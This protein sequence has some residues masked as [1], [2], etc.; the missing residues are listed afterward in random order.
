M[1]IENKQSYGNTPRVKVSDKHTMMAMHV[2]CSA[3]IPDTSI[4]LRCTGVVYNISANWEGGNVVV[5]PGLGVKSNYI[6]YILADNKPTTTGVYSK[7]RFSYPSHRVGINNDEGITEA[8]TYINTSTSNDSIY[9]KT[10]DTCAFVVKP[11]NLTTTPN[12]LIRGVIEGFKVF[13]AKQLKA[14]H[15][16]IVKTVPIQSGDLK[17]IDSYID[18][19]LNRKIDETRHLYGFTD[20][21]LYTATAKKHIELMR[22]MV[23]SYKS[24]SKEHI[25]SI[26]SKL[27]S[28]NGYNEES[29][30]HSALGV[31]YIVYEIP[32]VEINDIDETKG[33]HY[34]HNL[35]VVVSTRKFNKFDDHPAH[36][37]IR[38]NF[39]EPPAYLDKVSPQLNTGIHYTVSNDDNYS[40]IYY[41]DVDTVCELKPVVRH[42]SPDSLDFNVTGALIEIHRDHNK[43][44]NTLKTKTQD[45]YINK[46]IYKLQDALD[47]FIV[48]KS[49]DDAA[50]H[51]TR[52]EIAAKADFKR[53]EADILLAEN[54]ITGSSLLLDTAKSNYLLEQENIISK[55]S[56]LTLSNEQAIRTQNFELSRLENLS[57]QEA[58]KI[59]QERHR[60]DTTLIENLAKMV[61]AEQDIHKVKTQTD[62]LMSERNHLHEKQYYASVTAKSDSIAALWKIIPATILGVGAIALAI[63]K[64]KS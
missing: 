8:T 21:N 54:K 61:K 22:Q 27:N 36:S 34:I 25:S 28:V 37:V 46:S 7:N 20:D 32:I 55:L 40:S 58:D 5:N 63:D 51:L 10:R 47:K 16:Y 52:R 53:I 17:N 35:D 31:I 15:L 45:L 2:P 6:D 48:F 49:Y 60:Y 26:S 1:S 64:L 29:T 39:K 38:S 12:K 33:C 18:V 59:Q 56:A 57:R 43:Q 30:N 19:Q 44:R 24:K 50:S 62:M 11:T 14:E 9:V 41:I 3:V 42:M 4:V 13:D 23:A